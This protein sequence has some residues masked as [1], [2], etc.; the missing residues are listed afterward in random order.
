MQVVRRQGDGAGDALALA[1]GHQE[2]AFRADRRQ[3]GT[4]GDTPAAGLAE[5]DL[6]GG[7]EARGL[8]EQALGGEEAGGDAEA[9]GERVHGGLGGLEVEGDDAADA[10]ARQPVLGEDR[11]DQ[12]GQRLGWCS[13]LGADTERE[14]RRMVDE[15]VGRALDGAVRDQQL[16]GCLGVDRQVRAR[17][18]RGSPASTVS[19]TALPSSS[20]AMTPLACSGLA[21]VQPGGGAS[22]AMPKRL[23]PAVVTAGATPSSAAIF[24]A[25]SLAP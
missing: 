8:G 1:L 4:F 12:V 2:A 6:G 20:R 24:R 17:E 9:G 5:H 16:R 15:P 14:D 22:R 3:G 25:S 11:V 23:S 18:P 13:G 7:G 10:G 21:R 19:R